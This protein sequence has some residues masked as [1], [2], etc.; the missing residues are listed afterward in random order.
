MDTT[1][2]KTKNIEGVDF[3]PK[4]VRYN[5]VYKNKEIEMTFN[6][7]ARTFTADCT[8]SKDL[9][10][11]R[12][13]VVIPYAFFNRYINIQMIGEIMYYISNEIFGTEEFMHLLVKE[14]V[15]KHG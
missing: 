8:K 4:T 6:N 13:K 3:F 14:D 5:F 12:I 1:T 2:N 7:H 11:S 15:I 9:L 10:A